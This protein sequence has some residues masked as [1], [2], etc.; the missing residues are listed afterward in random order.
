L[1]AASQGTTHGR[2]RCDA[3]Q[4]CPVAT[5][6]AE[7]S[8]IPCADVLLSHRR[9]LDLCAALEE[10]AD[11]LPGR[12]DRLKCLTIASELVPLLRQSHSF[13]E[14]VVFPAF[15]QSGNAGARAGSVE[16]LQ[17]E[18]VEDDC[19]ALDLTDMLLAI[20]HGGAIDNPEALGFMLRAFFE[21]VRRHIAFEREH[22]LPGLIIHPA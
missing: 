19:A 14:T 4:D 10:I 6:C 20:G 3:P 9:K 12:V 15:L 5:A 22:V 13:E 11:A 2:M 16:R 17:A 21:S 1:I 7:G 8:R 18:H